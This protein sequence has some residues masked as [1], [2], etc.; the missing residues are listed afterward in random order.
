MA[1]P[2]IAAFARVANGSAAPARKV[3]GQKS[4]LSRV[5]HSIVYD[6]VHDEIVVPHYFAQGILT[7]R[8]GVNGEEPPIRIIQGPHTRLR[9]PDRLDVDPVH[10][11]IFVPQGE[12]VLVFPRTAVG[13]VAPIR[14]L[15]GFPETVSAIAVGVDPI[16]NL[17]V[18]GME[19]REGERGEIGDGGRT[20]I[21][22][23]EIERGGGAAEGLYIYNRTD[24]GNAKPRA[25]IG[26]PKNRINIGG[27]FVVYPPREEI[28]VPIRGKSGVLASDADF[29]GVWSLKDNGDVPPRWTIGGPKGALEH[30]H[31]VALN[32][33]HKEIIISDKRT[34]SVL[35]YSFP[36][37]F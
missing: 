33:K 24:A 23:S 9:V 1:H 21:G 16:H 36:E 13:D 6:S 35:T 8:G 22:R 15:K 17:L 10:D 28:I 7:F 19:R 30:V 25:V 37:M 31:G 5:M 26:G 32:P 12:E 11:E 2:Q 4:V 34:N 3:E 29:V 14:I 18:V 27:P 20:E